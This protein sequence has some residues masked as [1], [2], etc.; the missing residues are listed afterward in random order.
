MIEVMIDVVSR[1]GLS[2]RKGRLRI[3][4]KGEVIEGWAL[5]EWIW[6]E[7]K[8]ETRGLRTERVG[9]TVLIGYKILGAVMTE[10]GHEVVEEPASGH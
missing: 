8:T 1:I 2:Q 6:N 10:L 7:G 3:H 9:P 4:Q 5:Y